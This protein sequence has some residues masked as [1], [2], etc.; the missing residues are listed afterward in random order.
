MIGRVVASQGKGQAIEM[1]AVE[2]RLLGES[3]AT[4][5]PLTKG[6][7][8]LPMEYLRTMGH[9]RGRTQIISSIMR[10]RNALAFGTH[11]F[12]Q[13]TLLFLFAMNFY[14]DISFPL[15]FFLRVSTNLEVSS[16]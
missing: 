7:Q 4:T 9:F 1:Q 14:F 11:A 3:N 12:F 5:Y 8:A 15:F 13:V 6:K 10:V 16:N 2:F